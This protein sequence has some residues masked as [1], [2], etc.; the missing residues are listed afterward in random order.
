MAVVN[1]K[2][3]SNNPFFPQRDHQ[4]G[5]DLRSTMRLIIVFNDDFSVIYSLAS[6]RADGIVVI[7][8]VMFTYTDVG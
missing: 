3:A 5:V 4:H 6:G 7:A 2:R 8:I 1:F